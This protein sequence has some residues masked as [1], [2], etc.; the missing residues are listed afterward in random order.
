MRVVINVCF[1]GF[2]LSNKALKRLAELQGRKCYFFVHRFG[3]GTTTKS[4]YEPAPEDSNQ[5]FTTAFDIHNPGELLNVFDEHDYENQN[6]IYREHNIDDMDGDRTNP[7][8]I[9]V[10]E[11]LGDEANGSCAKLKI[12]EIPDGIQYEIEEYDGNEHI[13]EQHQTWS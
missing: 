8:L 13:A 4:W 2:G 10:V 12:V 7:L 6:K 9:Q 1:G 5:I 3:N 11:E